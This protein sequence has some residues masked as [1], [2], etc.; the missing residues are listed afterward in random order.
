MDATLN[1]ARSYRAPSLEER[2]QFI[3][4]GGAT[5]LG[6]VNLAA[7]KG[8]TADIGVRI[9]TARFSLRANAFINA[10]N[11]LVIDERRS[12]TLYAK[13]NLGEALLQGGEVTLEYN[14]FSVFVLHVNA[15]YV[16]GRDTGNE[17]DLPQM[18]PL[19]TRIGLRMPVSGLLTAE[20]LFTAAA[21]QD[22]VAEGEAATP[23]YGLLHLRL[24]SEAFR[25]S[26]VSAVLYAGVDNVFDRSW[27]RHLSTLRGIIVDEPGR[28]VFFRIH[29]LF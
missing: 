9:H 1:L 2:Y 17:S 4:L 24:R 19:S 13:N 29:L 12:D 14:P 8:N 16:R 22:A 15:A 27:R 5:Y 23:G 18:P 28:N 25:F 21:D 7:E 6:D 26:G 10:M 20:L 11:D 3:E